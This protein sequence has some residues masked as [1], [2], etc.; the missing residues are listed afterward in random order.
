MSKKKQ[1]NCQGIFRMNPK[2]FGFVIP[3]DPIAFPQDIFIPKHL[4]AGAIDGDIVIVDASP[5]SKTDKGPEG[6]VISIVQRGRSKLGGIVTSIHKSTA[7]IFTPLLGQERYIHAKIPEGISLQNG[8]RVIVKVLEW[9]D[10]YE[11]LKAEIISVLG[12]IADP[13]ID[14]FAAAEEF[15]IPREFSQ[16]ALEEARI[17]GS[18]VSATDKKNRVNLTKTPCITIDPTTAKDFD[19]A[20]SL[21][22]DDKGHYHLGVHIADVSHY[23]RPGTALDTEAKERANSTYFPGSCLPMLPEELSNHLCSLKP[24]VIR[25][26][27]SVFMTF[28]A[29]GTL[30]QHDIKRSFIKSAKRFTYEEA[31]LVLDG[32]KKSSF[33][34]MLTLMKDL[35]CHLKRKRSERGC[36]DFALPEVVL[37]I[38]PDGNPTSYHIVEY[39]ITHQLVEEFM[40]KANEVVAKAIDIQGLPLIFRVHEAPAQENKKT[41]LTL[42]RA[43]GFTIGENPTPQ[44]I[45][46]LFTDASQTPFAQQL[47]VAFIRSMKLA[48]YSADNI[49]HFGLS[50]ENYCHFTSPIR[51]YPDLLIHRLLF[52]DPPELTELQ[53]LAQH[54]SDKERNSFKAEQNVKT[55]KKLRLLQRWYQQDPERI[56]TCTITKIRPFSLVF[57]LSPLAVEGSLHVSE[58]GNDYFIYEPQKNV[59]LGRRTHQRLGLG[60][61]LFMRIT[62]IDFVWQEVT[63]QRVEDVN[64]PPKKPSK[65][66]KR[67]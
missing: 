28:D 43:L 8:D 14:V 37:N 15:C 39:D 3:E 13:S 9:D 64:D 5:S 32:K 46:K 35:A 11:E 29:E 45:Q 20:L 33:L 12:S 67:R 7:L 58:I 51:R 38:D 66:K 56:Y 41:F 6:F 55:L 21:I 42:A 59:F 16:K 62:Y 26:C 31:K 53:S 47:S 19:D 27:I 57:E 30:L 40:L 50:L 24:E 61:T 10:E 49:G 63:W 22:Q 44:E 25:L 1:K 52:E 60:D 23:V 36:V 54:C 65:K 34:P 48:C 17:F 2:G 18:Q 4:T